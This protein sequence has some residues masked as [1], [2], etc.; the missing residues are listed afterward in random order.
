MAGSNLDYPTIGVSVF[1]G[2]AVVKRQGNREQ[3]LFLR[4]K[5]GRVTYLSRRS[6]SK[7]AFLVTVNSGWLKSMITLT[8]P[9]NYP[10]SG[11]EA[12][13]DLN[14]FLVALKRHHKGVRYIW[15]MEFQERGAPHF[16]IL[17]DQSRPPRSE[18][19]KMSEIWC[20]IVAPVDWRYS[21]LSDRYELSLRDACE[22]FNYRDEFWEN[23]KK[24]DGLAHYAVC[25]ATKL[26]QKKPP[27]WFN[28][29]GRFW[30]SSR[31]FTYGYS[32][33]FSGDDNAVREFLASAGRD[34]GGYEYLPKI[35]FVEK[36]V[37]EKILDK[38]A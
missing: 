33:D 3:G 20:N 27:E 38:F 24:P 22:Y 28:L 8:Y 25:Y 5:R 14:A 13:G 11:K 32:V 23:Q 26:E 16:H 19:R 2:V 35:C 31:D 17:L 34:F 21:R 36:S 4:P 37:T 29:T 15:F 10:I 12:K 9:V 30:G 6:L 1:L 7:L 18:V